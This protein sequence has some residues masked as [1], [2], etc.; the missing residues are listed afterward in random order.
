MGWVTRPMT[1]P[2]PICA[3]AGAGARAPAAVFK[4][5]TMAGAWG[6]PNRVMA[7]APAAIR[8][9]VKEQAKVRARPLRDAS[10]PSADSAAA[11][12]PPLRIGMVTHRLTQQ[13]ARL[14][15]GEAGPFCRQKLLCRGRGFVLEH[16]GGRH[17]HFAV[18]Q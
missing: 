7:R 8:Q 11:A 4:S 14:P 6:R 17:R 9:M 13:K 15:P 1:G 16:G 5:T 10:K 18:Q 2:P 12:M 3:T